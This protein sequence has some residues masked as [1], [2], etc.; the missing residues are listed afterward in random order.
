MK[1]WLE[2]P[3]GTGRYDGVLNPTS[4]GRSLFGPLRFPVKHC[5][6]AQRIRGTDDVMKL[7]FIV[8]PESTI[9]VP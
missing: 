1:M 4:S 6:R 9:L 7:Y 8:F 3:R 2:S 5:K